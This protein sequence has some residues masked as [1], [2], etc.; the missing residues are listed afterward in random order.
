M[1]S[2]QTPLL[3]PLAATSLLAADAASPEIRIESRVV[4]GVPK[5]LYIRDIPAPHPL[6]LLSHGFT[7]DKDRIA[8][9]YDA[10]ALARRGWVVVCIDN[11]LHGE[12]PG[13]RFDVA[14]I[15]EGKEIALLAL[16]RAIKETA[17]DIPVLLDEL[18]RASTRP[19][20]P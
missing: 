14:V 4:A 19:A 5:R 15:R 6:L 1:T 18:L 9:S 16:R 20:S 10:P 17:D 12:R 7:G 2:K 8:E 11:R 13:P 3:T